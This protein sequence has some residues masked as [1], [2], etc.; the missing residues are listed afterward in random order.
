MFNKINKQWIR[1]AINTVLV[2]YK[3]FDQKFGSVYEKLVVQNTIGLNTSI[4]M[5]SNRSSLYCTLLQAYTYYMI[6]QENS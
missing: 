3:P 6:N 2:E 1:I 4:W 5:L